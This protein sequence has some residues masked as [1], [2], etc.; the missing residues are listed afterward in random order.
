MDP[1]PGA[2]F[3][4]KLKS[5]GQPSVI[6]CNPLDCKLSP[7][8]AEE[9]K[10]GL[11]LV[12]YFLE[13]YDFSWVRPTQLLDFGPDSTAKQFLKGTFQFPDDTVVP[14]KVRAASPLL[15]IDPKDSDATNP[16]ERSVVIR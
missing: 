1:A 13:P 9:G 2:I 3:R 4:V 8:V 7:C 6:V 14:R 11:V 16:A 15:A 12:R 5:K 10:P